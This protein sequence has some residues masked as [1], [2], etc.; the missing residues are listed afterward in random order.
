[1]LGEVPAI[2]ISPPTSHRGAGVFLGQLID[3]PAGVP[4]GKD[5]RAIGSR[6]ATAPAIYTRSFATTALPFGVWDLGIIRWQT[7]AER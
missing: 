2:G 5:W 6:L 7:A 3:D 1:M 4:V